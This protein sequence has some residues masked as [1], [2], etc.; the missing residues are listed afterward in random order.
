MDFIVQPELKEEFLEDMPTNTAK[1]YRST[2]KLADKYE[3]SINKSIYDMSLDELFDL[4]SLQYNNSSLEAILK[5]KSILSEYISFCIN[6]GF[7]RHMENRLNMLSKKDLKEV[8]NK[9]ALEFKY[10]SY[11]E[12]KEYQSKLGNNQD[13]LLL[14]APYNGIRGRTQI[15]AT[16]EEIINL[17]VNPNSEQVK[18]NILTLTKNNG[19]QRD[20]KVKSETMKLIIDTLYDDVY[21]ENNNK[22]TNNQRLSKIREIKINKFKNYV[23]RV[24]GKTKYKFFDP[25]FINQR[26][27]RIQIWVGNDYLT[28]TSLYYSGMINMVYRD[29]LKEKGYVTYQDVEKVC[30]HFD[31]PTEYI[32]KLKEKIL[33]YLK[34]EV[35]ANDP[36]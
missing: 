35:I 31:Y 12:L 27:G 36:S 34:V 13:K 8:V 20:I 28:I 17:T 4:I 25:N 18:N 33:E 7:V 2:L 24:P 29:Y 3:E 32:Y 23:F 9:Q 10:I 30:G 21:Y 5:D 1:S 22:Q 26:M 14:E 16:A 6:K 11:E 15:E 19:L